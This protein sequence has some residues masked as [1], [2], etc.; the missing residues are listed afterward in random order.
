[1]RLGRT[2]VGE[3]PELPPN[4]KDAL[5]RTFL[6]VSHVPLRAARR[7]EQHRIDVVAGLQRLVGQGGAVPVDRVPADR[8]RPHIEP[9]PEPLADFVQYLDRLADNLRPDAVSGQDRY[10]ELQRQPPYVSH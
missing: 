8:P 3:Q 5:F 10:C 9:V 6:G 7:A 2:D 4:S 1:M